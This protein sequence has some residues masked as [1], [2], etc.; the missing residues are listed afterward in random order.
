[1]NCS[2]CHS[3]KLKTSGFSIS[4]PASVIGGGSKFGTAVIS[5]D[6]AGSPLVRILKGQIAPRMPMGKSLAEGEIAVIEQ[7]VRELKPEQISAA[8]A[9]DWLWAYKKPVHRELPRVARL[10]W[11]ANPIDAFVL[12]QLEDR[13][14][15]PAPSAAKRVLARRLYFDLVGMPPTPDELHTFLADTS[16]D[17]YASLV[18]KLLADPRYGE[19]WGRHWLDLARYGETSGLEGD[20]AIGNAWRYRDW[21]IEAFNSDMP[22][23]R[24]VI[25]QLAGGDEHSQTRNNYAPDVQGMVPV[26][27]LRPL[28]P[29]ESCGR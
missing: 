9:N 5:G 18:D 19:H 13:K 21:V 6:P 8:K 7:W 15:G 20:G 4:T 22:Y 16:L 23:D 25:K 29:L 3:D 2:A 14:M 27:F 1:M 24:F 11:V 10:E 26:A 12:K 28:G 17:A